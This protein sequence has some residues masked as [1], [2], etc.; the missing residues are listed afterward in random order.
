MPQGLRLLGTVLFHAAVF[1]L[2]PGFIVYQNWSTATALAREWTFTGPPCPV[3]EQPSAQ[4]TRHGKPPMTVSYGGAVFTRSFAAASCGAVPINPFWPSENAYVCR[5]NNPGAVVVRAA[6]RRI[7]FQ[8][9]V[10]LPAT[11]T[12]RRGQ[13]SCVVAGGFG[14]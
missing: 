10:G 3:V 1:S 11:V 2:I 7:V 12:V 8:P 9:P 4:A 5:F 6:G 14:T 13:V